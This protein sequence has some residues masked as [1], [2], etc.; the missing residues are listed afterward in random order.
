MGPTSSS[1]AAPV[2]LGCSPLLLGL[3]TERRVRS[4][5]H[6]VW[7]ALEHARARGVLRNAAQR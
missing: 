2:G 3:E 1:W 7:T 5:T 4:E 6:T